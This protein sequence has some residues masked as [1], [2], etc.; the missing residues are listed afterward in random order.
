MTAAASNQESFAGSSLSRSIPAQPQQ[1][2]ILIE[3]EVPVYYYLGADELIDQVNSMEIRRSTYAPNLTR[4]VLAFLSTH[5]NAENL[6]LLGV[7]YEDAIGGD[8]QA[9]ISES[10]HIRES[11][12]V[13]AL[14]GITEEL[15]IRVVRWFHLEQF[16]STRNHAHYYGQIRP[17][18]YDLVDIDNIHPNPSLDDKGPNKG[19]ASVYL[20]GTFA[21]LEPILRGYQPP[22]GRA[23]HDQIEK[24]CAIPFSELHRF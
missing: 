2:E 4:D 14:R 13:T 24:L 9:G 5:P 8:V 10:S 17:H 23:N 7:K 6:Y 20:Y 22:N 16:G 19:K 12:I 11:R 21:D 18:D 1:I 15:H 3:V